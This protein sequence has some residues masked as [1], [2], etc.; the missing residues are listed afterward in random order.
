MTTSVTRVA[1]IQ[2][3]SA[4]SVAENIET[5]KHLIAEAA[6]QGANLILLPEYWASMGMHESDKLGLAEQIDVGPIQA[7]MAEAAREHRIWLIG[8][9][10]PMAAPVADKVLN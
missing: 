8:G 10:L 3:I 2:M 5:A 6:R 1:A 9:T 7:F 4:P